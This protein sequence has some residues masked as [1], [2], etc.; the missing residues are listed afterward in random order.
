MYSEP[1]L[2]NHRIPYQ[3]R[4]IFTPNTNYPLGDFTHFAYNQMRNIREAFRVHLCQI[5]PR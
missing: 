2:H 4:S 3:E 1:L 5:I